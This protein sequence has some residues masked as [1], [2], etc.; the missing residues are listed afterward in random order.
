MSADYFRMLSEYNVWA[1]DRILAA[2]AKVPEAEYFAP[3]DGL[4]FGNL[5]ATLVHA[6]VAEIIWQARF[7]G[8]LPPS[9]IGDPRRS[10]EIGQEVIPTFAEV[11]RLYAEER[12]KQDRFFASLSDADVTRDLSYRSQAGDPFVQ[13]LQEVLAHFFN[14]STQFRTEAAVRLT[15]LGSSPGD[16]DLIVFL[17][18]RSA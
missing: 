4:S 2:A 1:N 3:A 17:R 14:H 16:L 9:V 13:P 18:Q 6:L 7:E 5:H 8:G 10:Q 12:E 15:Q 11:E